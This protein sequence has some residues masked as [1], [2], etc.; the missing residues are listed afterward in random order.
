MRSC[1]VRLCSCPEPMRGARLPADGFSDVRSLR[2]RQSTVHRP[3]SRH[4]K[5]PWSSLMAT[6]LVDC[7][8]AE[9]SSA[10]EAC[11]D[12]QGWE[13]TSRGCGTSRYPMVAR[14]PSAR[15][16]SRD[17]A[18]SLGSAWLA[19]GSDGCG[20]SVGSVVGW[21][22]ALGVSDAVVAP[23]PCSRHARNVPSASAS[24][25]RAPSSCSRRTSACPRWRA[26]SSIVCT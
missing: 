14:P 4:C 10:C 1:G 23:Y 26:V 25:A 21:A 24:V 17:D 16:P 15:P 2:R 20:L 18:G 7:A 5:H 22:N 9:K 13:A 19:D 12:H 8:P 6:L 11:L 3:D